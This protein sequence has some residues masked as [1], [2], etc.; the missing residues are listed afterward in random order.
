MRMGVHRVAEAWL[1]AG[2]LMGHVASARAEETPTMVPPEPRKQLPSLEL[3]ATAGPSVVFGQPAN[4]EYASSFRRV[5]GMAELAIAYRSSYFIDPFLAV[6]Y[7]N[8]A[9]GES[10]MPSGPWGDGGTLEQFLSTWVIAPGITSDLWRFRLRFGLGIAVVAQSFR[11]VGH[12]DSSTQLPLAHQFGLG[13]NAFASDR[14]RIDGEARLILA[15]GADV[16]FVALTVV[17]RGDLVQ[18][19][20]RPATAQDANGARPG[21]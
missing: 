11:F 12:T 15:P 7:A 19:G 18:F 13:F 2:C 3:S 17:G 16:S 5:G 10:R 20:K 1:L 6:A 9:S 14:F 8:L 21:Y 4:P